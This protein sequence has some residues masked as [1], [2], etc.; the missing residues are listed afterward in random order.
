M[1]RALA[2]V[3]VLVPATAHADC[4]MWGLAPKVLTPT[5]GVVATDGGIVVAAVPEARADLA[6]GDPAVQSGWRLRIAGSLVK[7][8]TG[9]RYDAV[10]I[11]VGRV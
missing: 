6:P 5:N 7:P 1:L 2:I 3:A 4:A 9:S 8:P 10:A 11:G